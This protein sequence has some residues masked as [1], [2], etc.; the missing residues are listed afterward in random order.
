[1]NLGQ[2]MLVVATLGLLGLVALTANRTI[3]D[4]NT[5]QEQSEFGVTAVSLATS[6]IEEAMGKVFDASIGDTS[7]I[8]VSSLGQLTAPSNLGHHP[9]R[10]S[11]H[12]NVSGTLDFNDFDDFR[13]LF[14]IYKDPVDV[15][16]DPPGANHVFLVPGIRS[17][18]YVRANVTYVNPTSLDDSSAITTWHKKI[19]VT[20]TR[21]FA[22]IG[23]LEQQRQ[24]S[25]ANTL[26]FPSIMS[27][28]N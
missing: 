23:S 26:V 5:T 22:R 8:A 18:Y 24:D 20:V 14:V 11:Y 13:G 16:S 12:A 6:I 10:E 21:P 1:M 19:R 25:V 2:M 28:W 7:G 4:S 17:K 3:M 27:Y 9:T 15:S